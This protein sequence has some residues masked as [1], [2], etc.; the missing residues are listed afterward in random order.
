MAALCEFVFDPVRGTFVCRVCGYV[1]KPGPNHINR[2]RPPFRRCRAI[3]SPATRACRAERAAELTEAVTRLASFTPDADNTPG[4]LKEKLAH[5]GAALLRWRAVGYPVRTDDEVAA[6]L[7]A[8]ECCEKWNAKKKRCG[9][10]GC[11]VNASAWAIK[12]KARM[13]TEDCP[14]GLW[15]GSVAEK[16]AMKDHKASMEGV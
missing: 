16:K 12:N 4:S 13:A 8:C 6:C 11:N 15:P 2:N 7:A 10:C 1:Y 9:V 3:D 5:Y 14:L